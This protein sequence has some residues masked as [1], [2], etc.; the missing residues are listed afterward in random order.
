VGGD[1]AVKFKTDATNAQREALRARW[2]ARSGGELLPGVERWHVAGGT[3]LEA[4]AQSLTQ[5]PAVE[6]AQPD[7][8]R[9]ICTYPT[10]P[11]ASQ[12]W[13]LATQAGLNITTAWTS[14]SANPPGNG[15]VVA[16]VD[17]GIDTSHPDLAANIATDASGNKRFIDEVGDGVEGSD[18]S[19]HNKDG[20]GHGTHV[21]G[22][23]AAN[24]T[25]LGVAPGAKLLPVKTMR[26]TGDGDDF[27]IAK[28][29]KD[30]AD[31]GAV[32]INLSV[33][34][35]DPSPVLAEA[36]AYDFSKGAVVVIASG[37]AGQAVYY[38]AAYRG[39]ISVGAV[40]NQRQ[41]ASYS[42]RG[43]ELAIVA[44]GGDS[45]TDRARGIYSTF[46]TYDVVLNQEEGKSHN[47]AVQAGTSMATPMVSGAAALVIAEARLKG[48]SLSPEQVRARLLASATSIEGSGYHNSSGYGMLN[49]QGAL[50]WGSHDGAGL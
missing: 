16:I 8:L 30:A 37:N 15:V 17:T 12:Q 10:P 26:S 4:I 27:T 9:R 45:P 34:G 6:F 5:D 47:Y 23:V 43:K 49:P 18:V 21:A 11:S 3:D 35:P 36:I 14:A 32:I 13:F 19:Y 39:V 22:I 44:P 50:L 24:G 7:R 38:P 20:N 48:Q 29:L 33:R 25:I 40:N 41:V 42:N 28:G 31:A 46:P 2:G 1:L